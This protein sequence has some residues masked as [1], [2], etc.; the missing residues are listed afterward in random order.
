[1]LQL[2]LLSTLFIV[3]SACS[4]DTRTITLVT[5]FHVKTPVPSTMAKIEPRKNFH[6]GVITPQEEIGNGIE[7]GGGPIALPNLNLS[8]Y[9]I[10]DDIRLSYTDPRPGYPAFSSRLNL[11]T[12][13]D[14]SAWN[15]TSDPLGLE[16]ALSLMRNPSRSFLPAPLVFR[17]PVDSRGT[18]RIEGTLIKPLGTN[19]VPCPKYD[20]PNHVES[21]ALTGEVTLNPGG[22]AGIQLPVNVV[23]TMPRNNS[24]TPTPYSTPIKSG[25]TITNPAAGPNPGIRCRDTTNKA[26]CM[27][28]NLLELKVYQSI[29]QEFSIETKRNHPWEV[30][31]TKF[32][33]PAGSNGPYYFYLTK[34]PAIE[35]GYTTSGG[36]GV[37]VE[38]NFLEKKYKWSSGLTQS[39]RIEMLNCQNGLWGI[40]IP[41]GVS[42]PSPPTNCSFY[43]PDDFPS[44]PNLMVRDL[45]EGFY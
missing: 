12:Q 34:R 35:I 13:R 26:T 8:E 37:I 4:N 41:N 19:A 39:P 44:G 24:N 14:L 7:E 10:Q 1:M 42:S 9:C 21:F 36:N 40:T 28:R 30:I 17:L 31:E 23:S 43:H 16:S 45:G 15:T 3:L 38:I 20:G 18:F 25:A 11:I 29:G 6:S 33:G 27:N 32:M 2:I 5:P 22:P